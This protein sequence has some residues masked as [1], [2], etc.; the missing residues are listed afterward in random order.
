MGIFGI[1]TTDTPEYYAADPQIPSGLGYFMGR[2]KCEKTQRPA[3]HYY[4]WAVVI[5]LAFVL[6][7]IPATLITERVYV[8]LH[9]RIKLLSY[10]V[11][12]AQSKLLVLRC[13]Y[14][15]KEL[16]E[17]E[18]YAFR[19]WVGCEQC[20]RDYYRERSPQEIESQLHMRQANARDW[21]TRNRK[22][23][24]RVMTRGKVA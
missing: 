12:A 16:T 1:A 13:A 8:L 24:A 6:I 9:R 5:A 7:V 21:L 15:S 19:G 17:P 14:C 20:V 4:T 23:L 3:M 2:L 22:I 11:L 18:M 10:S